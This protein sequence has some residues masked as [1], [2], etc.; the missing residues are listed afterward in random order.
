MTKRDREIYVKYPEDAILIW[1]TT[2]V[3]A[4]ARQLE[5]ACLFR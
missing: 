3:C 4:A 5:L 1:P 2:V